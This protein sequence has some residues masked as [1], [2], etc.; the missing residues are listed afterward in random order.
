MGWG[1]GKCGWWVV[2]VSGWVARH[3]AVAWSG[4]TIYS[5]SVGKWMCW[6]GLGGH[7][8]LGQQRPAAGGPA[9]AGG[10]VSGWLAELWIAVAAAGCGCCGRRLL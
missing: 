8:G 10:M 4:E 1:A 3:R 6:W 2:V 7:P 5:G 9:G